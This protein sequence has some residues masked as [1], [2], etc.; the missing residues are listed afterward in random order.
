[1]NDM[2]DEPVGKVLQRQHAEQFVMDLQGPV[3]TCW[4]KHLEAVLEAKDLS[5]SRAPQWLRVD[6]EANFGLQ[7]KDL[8]LELSPVH[9]H[10]FAL[11]L[12]SA[13]ALEGNPQ[14]SC[15]LE[16]ANQ[17]THRA[18]ETFGHPEALQGSYSMDQMQTTTPNRLRR[19]RRVTQ[20]HLSYEKARSL[21]DRIESFKRLQTEGLSIRKRSAI[22]LWWEATVQSRARYVADALPFNVFFA[23]VILSNSL[24]LG[25]QLEI[26]AS[27]E[28]PASLTV[29]NVIY[30]VLFT[31]EMCIRILAA[32]LS[33]YLF[34][35]G[36]GWNWLDV[37]LEDLFHLENLRAPTL[38]PVEEPEFPDSPDWGEG[39]PEEVAEGTEESRA[40]APVYV[41]FLEPAEEEVPP[42]PTSPF[43]VS[44]G[45]ASG[46]PE[47]E[48]IQ[49]GHS[50]AAPS[51]PPREKRRGTK[52][53]IAK[54]R[55]EQITAW[56]RDFNHFADWIWRETGEGFR[57]GESHAVALRI[58]QNTVLPDRDHINLQAFGQVDPPRTVWDH[59]NR[60]QGPHPKQ[61]SKRQSAFVQNTDP[62]SESDNPLGEDP[63]RFP[64]DESDVGE[65]AVQ[66]EERAA[67]REA[68]AKAPQ[69][70]AQPPPGWTPSLRPPELVGGSTTLAH[71]RTVIHQIT[72]PEGVPTEQAPHSPRPLRRKRRSQTVTLRE[73]RSAFKARRR[74]STTT[75][76]QEPD[77]IEPAAPDEE[78]L[79]EIPTEAAA[80]P[81]D[82]S[83]EP[84]E[85][86]EELGDEEEGEEEE[87]QEEDVVVEEAAEAPQDEPIDLEP[88]A[89]ASEPSLPTTV[90][91]SVAR[92]LASTPPTTPRAEPTTETRSRSR[93]REAEA[94]PI[95]RTIQATNVKGRLEIQTFKDGRK[96][97]V[98]VPDSPIPKVPPEN[99]KRSGSAPVTSQPKVKPPPA[100]LVVPPKPKRASSAAAS[101]AAAPAPQGEPPGFKPKERKA[102]P[103]PKLGEVVVE[104]RAY[105][106]GYESSPE[107]T[108]EQIA[109]ATARAER[110]RDK[111][112]EEDCARLAKKSREEQLKEYLEKEH[113]REDLKRKGTKVRPPPKTP[114]VGIPPKPD[115]PV[116]K[117]PQIE[118]P[119]PQVGGASSST[120]TTIPVP[121]PSPPPTPPSTPKAAGPHPWNQQQTTHPPAATREHGPERPPLTEEEQTQARLRRYRQHAAEWYG[122]DQRAQFVDPPAAVPSHRLKV[123]FDWHDT[124]DSA[125]NSVL[126]FDQSIVE[127]FVDLT[128]R[129]GNNIEYHIVSFA[130]GGKVRSTYET[131]SNLCEWLRN[132]GLPFKSV[133]VC[134]DPTGPNGKTPI[135]VAHEGNI[136]VDD[137]EDVCKEAARANIFTLQCY[138]SETL[139]WFPQLHNYIVQVGWQRVKE[140]H[141]PIPLGRNQYTYQTRR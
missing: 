9:F 53:G 125:L 134:S 63:A 37:T 21:G 112:Y 2:D 137:R 104:T 129:T 47:T 11:F 56:R 121:K 122:R 85:A 100:G 16:V 71:E 14:D 69:E 84:P 64:D 35:K 95:A 43:L 107:P 12:S 120:T 123:F 118:V 79:E 82:P 135:I 5:N 30:A 25:L 97:Q 133:S 77:P 98:F 41:H 74:T 44:E 99:L 75:T 86:P 72:E 80:S 91:G 67:A 52:G 24:F 61:P 10:A 96:A 17:E 50:A 39:V 92:F 26:K 59:Y 28:A 108:P 117:G 54:R 101:V 103:K 127:K 138:K 105:E 49:V 140:K 22:S 60:Y 111:K 128:R 87:N 88:E 116:P 76:R 130:G 57:K 102:P 115:R 106:P 83:S 119:V 70:P 66:R 90:K 136:L 7:S 78:D 113:K 6:E 32:G 124:L 62:P 51:R 29:V 94:V 31:G 46:A 15:D 33:T 114:P 23:F 27:G 1:M 81:G 126:L 139:S 38:S 58:L 13:F 73:R 141:H 65:S 42:P 45:A 8:A 132:R 89:E 20:S 34:G 36:A 4:F 109:E 110:A 68:A 18:K 131:A 93:H 3:S 19:S 55:S 48:P 40:A